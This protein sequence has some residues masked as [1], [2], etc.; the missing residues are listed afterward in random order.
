M[1]CGVL[2]IATLVSLAFIPHYGC[3]C[4]EL[5]KQNGSQLEYLPKTIAEFVIKIINAIF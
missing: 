5:L 2:L 1:L 3:T 4:G